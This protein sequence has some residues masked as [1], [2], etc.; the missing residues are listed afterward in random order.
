MPGRSCALPVLIFDD[1]V[2]VILLAAFF[3]RALAIDVVIWDL[4]QIPRLIER[5]VIGKA[6]ILAPL[7]F[8]VSYG[9]LDH[10]TNGGVCAPLVRP[11]LR[12]EALLPGVMRA[13][14][15]VQDKD[16][17][18]ARKLGAWRHDDIAIVFC[19]EMQGGAA[20]LDMLAL[21]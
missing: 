17:G 21:E 15:Q 9:K 6:G 10:A 8:E 7:D 18:G 3:A 13:V 2:I 4:R 16:R 1:Q 14:C 19:G 5:A 20:V 11:C 12:G